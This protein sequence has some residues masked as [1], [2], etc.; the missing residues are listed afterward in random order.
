MILAILAAATL[1]PAAPSTCAAGEPGAAC[2]ATVAANAG[3]FAEAAPEFETAAGRAVGPE[4]DRALAAAGNMWLAAGETAKAAVALDQALQG[5]GLVGLQRGEALIDRARVAFEQKNYVLARAK[6]SEAQA[7]AASDPFYWYFSAAVGIEEGKLD[8]A[9]EAN[10]RALALLPS[11]PAT[12]VQAGDLAQLRG[13]K[14]A[15]RVSY[16]QAANGSDAFAREARD[17]LARIDAPAGSA[18]A[19][20][21]GKP[22]AAAPRSAAQPRS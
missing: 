13:D 16:R 7:T 20:A 8:L 11:D 4:R 17:R 15:A 2:R 5:G 18:P 22:P 12:L 1:A 3:R 21:T 9:R 19:T 6:L 10:A 14:A